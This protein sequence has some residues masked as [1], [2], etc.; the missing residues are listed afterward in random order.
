M[1]SEL[2]KL[3]KLQTELTAIIQ[4]ATDGKI[5]KPQAADRISDVKEKTDD[6]VKNLKA[7]PQ[8]N[9]LP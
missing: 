4:E 1:N 9:V 6:I 2:Q 7:K 5:S 3:A 8:K